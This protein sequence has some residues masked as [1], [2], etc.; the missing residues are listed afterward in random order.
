VPLPDKNRHEYFV[1]ELKRPSLKVGRKELDQLE[2][3][4][5]ALKG[6][7]DF[8]HTEIAWNFFLVT[9]V[10]DESISDRIKQK[11][12]PPGL[13]LETENSR[14]WVKT[15]A[16]LILECEARLHFVQEKLRVEVSDAEIDTRISAL[17]AAVARV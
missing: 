5:S 2:D 9:G 13:F 6:Q 7:R 4:V 8:A 17:R 1:V 12:R 16:E 14:V 15:W 11:A 10:C 3:Y